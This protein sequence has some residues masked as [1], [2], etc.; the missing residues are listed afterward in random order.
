M[1]GRR[2][3]VI[4]L[5]VAVVAG[6]AL[7]MGR[8]G[9]REAARQQT[10][11]A[12]GP[13]V[14]GSRPGLADRD[15]SGLAWLWQ[16]GLDARHIAGRVVHGGRPVEKAVVRLTTEEL[17]IGEWALAEL[18]TDQEGRFDFGPRPAT[19]YQVVAQADG[20]VAGG[21]VVD[22]R[23]R[24]PRPAPD[25]VTVE[26]RDCELTVS[27]TV[28][29]AAGGIIA[30]ARVRAAS[31]SEVFASV[32]TDEQGS[33]QVCLL[34]GPAHIEAGA[35]GYGT[36][37]EHTR[38]R[39]RARV[40]FALSPEIA[41]AGRVVDGAGEPVGGAV[42]IAETD[43]HDPGALTESAADGGFRFERLGKGTYRVVARHDERVA[44]KV[45]ALTDTAAP[46]ELLL[47]LEPR[48]ALAGRV[49]AGG[50]P[51]ANATVL[52]GSVDEKW[53]LGSAVTQGDGRFAIAGLPRGPVRI[54]V[55]GHK[56]LSP[57]ASIDLAEVEQVEL[58]CERR[59]TV[60]GR[61]MRAG[62]PVV[63]AE[64]H[65]YEDW[66]RPYAV[67]SAHD[68]SFEI[69][70]VAAAS[71]DIYATSAAEGATMARRPIAVG[72][73]DI[74]GLVLDLDLVASIA[75]SVVDPSGAPVGGATVNFQR[76][77]G[78]PG[79]E[80]SDTTASDGS[81][82]VGGLA[83]GTYRPDVFRS[84]SGWVR[85]PPADGRRHAAVTIA[86]GASRVTG[87]RL[88]IARSDLT[89]SG[90]AVRRGAPVAGI[91][92]VAS[93]FRDGNEVRARSGPDGSFVLEGLAA[94]PYQLDAD[95]LGVRS[96]QVDAGARDVVLELPDSGKIEGVLHG[97]R[98]PLEV[99][100]S[101]PAVHRQADVT[102][103]RF[104]VA[105]I[106]VGTY[107]VS[108][109]AASGA[110]ATERVTVT[111]DQVSRVTLSASATATMRGVVKDIRTGAPMAGVQCYWT[112]GGNAGRPVATDAAGTF[113]FAVPTGRI[114]VECFGRRP[115]AVAAREVVVDVQPGATAHVTVEVISFRSRSWSGTIGVELEEVPPGSLR[116][117]LVHGGAVSSGLR[118]GDILVAVDGMP[119]VGLRVHVAQQL[120][121]DRNV[122]ATAKLT[123]EREGAEL[124]FDVVVE[125]GAV[126]PEDE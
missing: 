3:A 125:A 105:G 32:L 34:A 108:A 85:H 63:G 48:A 64:V 58:V 121:L 86:D 120:M 72:A 89:I 106:A 26:L 59:A 23:A 9:P 100:V 37:L 49:V 19:R 103:M 1:R 66:S 54:A 38:G 5:L 8:E 102:D 41:I 29:D 110:Y 117:Q 84:R 6:L 52:V 71:Y 46:A 126:P 51:A 45:V 93:S 30:G 116:V 40:D 31:R 114:Q 42:V 96:I 113:S 104:A 124:A 39:R 122:G 90:R 79:E 77:D 62:E 82:L 75:G 123:V 25:D 99:T 17:R 50:K 47:T 14:A 24:D 69:E 22:L 91:D 44:E 109:I 67:R 98:G 97:F 12:Q 20:L 57:D 107:D 74:A 2:L 112:I 53:T 94:G 13:G 111:A 68:G 61:V 21:V 60:R 70:G 36:A 65:L 7:W 101:G 28:R 27:G 119:V 80:A 43:G 10:G 55:E 83:G 81:F 115:S 88:V 118:V 15:A 92:V 4:V 18:E 73:Q 78:E 33:Y 16:R 35:D 95:G 11:A 76:D 56:L 87:V